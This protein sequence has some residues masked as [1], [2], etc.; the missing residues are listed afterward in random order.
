MILE[1]G[2]VLRQAPIKRLFQHFL[3]SFNT[4]GVVLLCLSLWQFGA[5]FTSAL[6]LPEPLSV[7]KKALEILNTDS[8]TLLITSK[9]AF[10]AIILAFF[11][12]STL[13]IVAANFKS[14]AAFIKPFVDILQG[15]APIIWVVIALF[16]F[17]I[18]DV[19]VVFVVFVT[20]TPLCFGSSFMSVFN[21]NKNLSELCKA[22]KLSILKR[23][24]VFYL[25]AMLPFLLSNL[26]LIFAMGIKIVVMAELLGAVNGVGARLNDARNFLDSEQIFAF[27]VLMVALIFLFES[28]IIKPL[29]IIFMPWQR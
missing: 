4:L 1:D 9:R 5:T 13:G 19:S 20:L 26:S 15:I 21:L 6:I 3:S 17:G 2:V 25:P 8:N 29:R 10:L 24:R 12:G 28:L 27:V 7:L 11:V 18:G 16:W 23:L 22:Y 14:F